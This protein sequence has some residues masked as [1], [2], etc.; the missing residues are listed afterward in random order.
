MTI[1]KFLGVTVD[2]KVSFSSHIDSICIRVSK[3]IGM[4]H[5]IHR[6][7]PEYTLI[8]LYYSIVY[9]HLIYGILLWGD[10]AD[11]YVNHLLLLQKKIIRLI[12]CSSYLAHTG[13]LFHRTGILTIRDVYKFVLGCYMFGRKNLLQYPVHSYNTRNKNIAIPSFQRLALSE[14]SLSCSGPKLWNS[15]PE[16]I[17]N[18]NSVANFKR[19]PKAVFC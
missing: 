12:T 19:S 1:F 5:K 18:C 14:R 16:E 13:P 8:K 7:V 15:L 17:R 9:P 11:I 2:H 10:S 4:F 6:D 3:T